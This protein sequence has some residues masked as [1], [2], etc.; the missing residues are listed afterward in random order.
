MSSIAFVAGRSPLISK[1]ARQLVDGRYSN[2]R[3]S[4][5]TLELISTD[6]L[7]KPVDS[8]VPEVFVAMMIITPV[9][10]CWTS[11]RHSQI[12]PSWPMYLPK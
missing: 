11:R 5:R 2:L 4:L 1:S 8:E 3:Y 7:A 9:H 10:G 6:S 12:P